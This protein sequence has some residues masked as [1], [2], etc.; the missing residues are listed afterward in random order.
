MD[1]LPSGGEKGRQHHGRCIM[2]RTNLITALALP[3]ALLLLIAV[4]MGASAQ[5]INHREAGVAFDAPGLRSCFATEPVDLGTTEITRSSGVIM[6][7]DVAVDNGLLFCGYSTKDKA[8]AAGAKW[9]ASQQP[10]ATP[11]STSGVTN[12]M[13]LTATKYVSDLMV[14]MNISDT[15]NSYTPGKPGF[16][17]TCGGLCWDKHNKGVLTWYGSAD[18]SEDI[19]QSPDKFGDGSKGP[20]D[21]MRDGDVTQVFFPI[22]REAQ[23]EVCGLKGA[24]IDGEAISKLLG[25]NEGECGR[26]TLKAGWH[27]VENLV[28]SR[29]AGFG[30]RF[31]ASGWSGMT[32]TKIVQFNKYWS[33]QGNKATWTGP[34]NSEI[35]M[36]PSMVAM[37][38][39][40]GVLKVISFTTKV[41]GQVL[42]CNG[43]VSGAANV[44]SPD[45]GC[46]WF[47]VPAGMFTYTGET[48][49]SAGVS[50]RPK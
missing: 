7:Y 14:R 47:D 40:F 31:T 3:I 34:D 20:L 16:P 33:V 24:T 28:N 42:L 44:S 30:V 41:P 49:T 8:D 10:P 27:V 4:V 21:L 6:T 39:D 29:V 50:W 18:G 25:K 17:A 13:N 2:K 48:R 46:Y 19:T 45:G 38:Q 36:V 5:G 12:T 32:E 35:L 9:L 26:G 11:A 43:N 15:V 1:S 22:Q 23:I 37:M